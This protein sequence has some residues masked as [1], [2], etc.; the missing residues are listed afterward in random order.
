MA[1]SQAETRERRDKKVKAAMS[2]RA[3][4]WLTNEQYRPADDSL[5]FN[6]VYADEV[7]GWISERFRY[8]SFNDVLYHMGTRTLSESEALTLQEKEPYIM[9]EVAEW[10]PNDPAKGRL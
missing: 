8:D 10:V 7:S 6:L 3:P 5:L 1:L 2:H 9:G 4:V